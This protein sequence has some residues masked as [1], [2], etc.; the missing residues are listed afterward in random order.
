MENGLG[1]YGRTGVSSTTLLPYCPAQFPWDF[2]R[3]LRWQNHGLGTSVLPASS[4]ARLYRASLDG[5]SSPHWESPPSL[6]EKREIDPCLAC[7]LGQHRHE[8]RAVGDLDFPGCD[9]SPA[10]AAVRAAC[11]GL[12]PQR[13]ATLQA[14]TFLGPELTTHPHPSPDTSWGSSSAERMKAVGWR[15]ALLSIGV[16]LSS[17][18]SSVPRGRK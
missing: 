1:N 15:L 5:G 13:A 6:Q 16:V 14:P 10:G 2:M 18:W 7:D 17:W 8:E 9:G 11:S 12:A 3:N 4:Q